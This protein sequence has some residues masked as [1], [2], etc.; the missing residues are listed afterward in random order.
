MNH[1]VTIY[2]GQEKTTNNWFTHIDPTDERFHN[3][4]IIQH[5]PKTILQIEEE[6]NI[7][8]VIE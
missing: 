1:P 4:K 8:I 6:Y 2:A 7:R 5:R 3:I